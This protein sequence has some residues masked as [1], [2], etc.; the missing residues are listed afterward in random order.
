MTIENEEKLLPKRAAFVEEYLVDFNGTQAAIRAGYSKHTA[1]EQAAR[2]LADASVIRAVSR[3]VE[4]R[5][6]RT[7]ITQ[8]YV[9]SVIRD[10]VERC[11]QAEP[12]MERADDGSMVPTGEW[13][14]DASS[15]LK[16]CDL[17]GKHLNM[18]VERREVTGKGG[19]PV[20]TAVT[21]F[22]LVPLVAG[23]D[24]PAESD[25]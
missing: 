11:R 21:V 5:S 8:D 15:V 25:D 9:L 10:T 1:N 12:V 17:L 7:E 16:G 22:E 19:G 4:K 3:A 2:L 18:W 23:S 24:S 13:K 20:Q 6:R 14:F